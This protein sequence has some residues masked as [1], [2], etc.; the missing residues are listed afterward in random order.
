[1]KALSHL[2]SWVFLPLFTPLYGLMI[3]LFVPSQQAFATF[4]QDSLYA[5]P[6]DLKWR[7]VYTFFFFGTF[8]PALAF[9]YL[10]SRKII[11][12]IEIEDRRERGLPILLMLGSC[13]ALYITFLLLP[14][15]S[16]VPKYL[17]SLPLSGV[18]S[19]VIFYFQTRWK[20]VSLHGGG[21]GIMT[22]F[23]FAY[24]LDHESYEM[25]ILWASILVSGLV[26]SARIYLGRHTLLEIIVGWFTGTFVTFVITVFY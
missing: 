1:M 22:G 18:V 15:G 21:V 26:G 24:V 4:N 10:K 9:I 7:L 14:D 20:K 3:A 12:T 8:L 23:L 2:I 11:S 25:W 13:V 17:Y 19:S 5:L 6:A 16:P